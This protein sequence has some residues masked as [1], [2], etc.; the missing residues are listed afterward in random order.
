MLKAAVFQRFER[1]GKVVPKVVIMIGDDFDESVICH[2]AYPFDGLSES[3][4]NEGSFGSF[5]L[6]VITASCVERRFGRNVKFPSVKSE[7][8][9][10][11]NVTSKNSEV[12]VVAIPRSPRGTPL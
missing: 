7:S 9:L 8:I 1:I 10:P 4:A 6:G 3:I 12:S 2:V 5:F 11:L